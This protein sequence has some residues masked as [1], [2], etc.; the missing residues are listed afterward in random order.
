VEASTTAGA[1][2]NQEEAA[3]MGR[4]QPLPDMSH[5]AAEIY[6]CCANLAVAARHCPK[7]WVVLRKL[8]AVQRKPL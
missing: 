6:E 5:F 4:L 1:G 2:G 8:L 7:V 3:V